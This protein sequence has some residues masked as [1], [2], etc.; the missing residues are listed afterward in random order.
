MARAYYTIVSGLPWL[1]RFDQAERLPISRER[2]GRRLADLAPEDA[3]DLEVAWG[4]FDPREPTTDV[5]VAASWWSMLRDVSSFAVRHYLLGLIDRR[6]LVSALRRRQRGE[7]ATGVY[8]PPEAA[9]ARAIRHRFGEPEFGLGAVHP[10][11]REVRELIEQADAIGLQRALST[12][13]WRLLT[14]MADGHRFQLE[15]VVAYALKWELTRS[16]VAHD[17]TVTTQMFRQLIEEVTHGQR[18][19]G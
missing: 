7:G 6:V 1:R 19:F 2:L 4:I 10:W 16:W 5:Q 18:L 11:L 9:S 12:V 15:E 3:R 8:L 17:T 13:E 14:A